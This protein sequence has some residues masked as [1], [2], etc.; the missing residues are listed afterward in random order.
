MHDGVMLGSR[1]FPPTQRLAFDSDGQVWVH[2]GMLVQ[3]LLKIY[4]GL[5]HTCPTI[6]FA[7]IDLHHGHSG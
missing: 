7:S 5:H 3:E 6:L 4:Q 1:D 2:G